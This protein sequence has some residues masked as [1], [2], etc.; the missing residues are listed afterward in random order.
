MLSEHPLFR[1]FENELELSPE[2]SIEWAM[3]ERDFFFRPARSDMRILC[4]QLERRTIAPIVFHCPVR[5]RHLQKRLLRNLVSQNY[6]RF[7]PLDEERE[8]VLSLDFALMRQIN[9]DFWL[10]LDWLSPFFKNADELLHRADIS[11]VESALE[12]AESAWSFVSELIQSQEEH[13]HWFECSRGDIEELK[14]VVWAYMTL[15]GHYFNSCQSGN[16]RFGSILRAPHDASANEWRLLR[17]VCE[18]LDKHFRLRLNPLARR[19]Y[20]REGKL[21]KRPNLYIRRPTPASHHERLEAFLLWRDFLHGK[22]PPEEIELLLA[23]Q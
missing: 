23:T 2:L 5:R 11:G 7:W 16:F 13:W 9:A 14:R 19:V 4:C 22:L 17:R 6:W 20:T 21:R 3:L 8:L 10:R 15:S 18:L 12:P 1:R